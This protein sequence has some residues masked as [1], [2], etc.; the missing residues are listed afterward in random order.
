[1]CSCWRTFQQ[2]KTMYFQKS[3]KH[4]RSCVSFNRQRPQNDPPR[5]CCCCWF[6]TLHWAPPDCL[7]DT[8]SHQ[9][10]SNLWHEHQAQRDTVCAGANHSRGVRRDSSCTARQGRCLCTPGVDNL[11]RA[12]SHWDGFTLMIAWFLLAAPTDPGGCWEPQVRENTRPYLSIDRM[13]NPA[14]Q[15]IITPEPFNTAPPPPPTTLMTKVTTFFCQRA[16][17]SWSPRILYRSPGKQSLLLE[18]EMHLWFMFD[19]H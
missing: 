13:E 7:S 14:A 8:W 19:C 11:I 12:L 9:L 2:T 6:H 3:I 10:P 5:S 15:A 16:D 18:S 17:Q 4:R 1:M